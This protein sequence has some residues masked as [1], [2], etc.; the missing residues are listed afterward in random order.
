MANFKSVDLKALAFRTMEKYGF[1]ARFSE[2]VMREVD[3][4]DSN[5]IL[6]SQTGK[7]KDLR[8]LLWSSIDNHDSLDLDQ[9][10]YCEQGS[11]GE[12]KVKVAIA[13]VDM[14]APKGSAADGHAH[15]NTTSVYTDIQLFPMFPDRMSSD[16]S[17]LKA[18]VDRLVVVIDFT[19]LPDG[20][21]AAGDVYRALVKN[22]A[23]LVYEEVGTWL[24]GK[25]P[26][27]KSVQDV[28]G[29]EAQ[30]RLQDEASQRL[31]EVR[32]EKGSLELDTIETRAIIK[33]E[34]ITD[35]VVVETNRAH[36][37]IEN[38]MVAAN[39]VVSD[40]LEAA[41][42]PVIQRIV[43]T[44]KYW[45]E[46]V[47]VAKTYGTSLPTEP[48]AIALSKFLKA[49]KN[50][51][52]LRFPD[53]SLTIVKLLGPGK[54]V[55]LAPKA[56]HIG[57][58]CLAATDYTHSTAPNRRYVDVIIQ[59][60]L[61]AALGKLPCPYTKEELTGIAEWCTEQEKSSKK[62]ERFMTKAEACTLLMGKIGQTFEAIVTGA[63]EKGTYARLFKPPVEGRIM[64]GMKG[65]KVGQKLTVK[66]ISLDPNKGFINFEKNKYSNI[67][68]RGHHK[69][70]HRHYA[71]KH[72]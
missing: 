70:Q 61:K 15:Q 28:P 46:I 68:K 42:I 38:F 55:M 50:A 12:I 69:A 72:L 44:P 37:L 51:D 41:D 63:S 49:R 11:D 5:N 16:L 45:N 60:L 54:Y 4:L 3:A 18:D 22:K 64:R 24:E 8:H 17:S 48:D 27:P 31:G 19:A 10:E 67:S 40:Y 6:K 2:E 34:K 20:C 56:P 21:T 65:L 59:R 14:F 1:R 13:D 57:H 52:P 29:L 47:E 39:G 53:L 26:L 36:K 33:D 25:G 9:I 62:V 32:V 71:K 23:K 30:L 43:R 66:L 58:F 7:V 35:L